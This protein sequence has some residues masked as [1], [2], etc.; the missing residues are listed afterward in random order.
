MNHRNIPICLRCRPVGGNNIEIGIQN[1][2]NIALD[3]TLT[4]F[5]P[6]D[7]KRND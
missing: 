7:H 4:T 3:N 5:K 2:L 6:Y 1:S